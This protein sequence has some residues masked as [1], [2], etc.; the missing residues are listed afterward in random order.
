MPTLAQALR[1]ATSDLS[2]GGVPGPEVDARLLLCAATGLDRVALIRD[3]DLPLGAEAAARFTALVG[4]RL[5]REP[6]SRILGFR[7]FWGLT[8]RVTPDVLDPRPDTKRWSRPSWKSRRGSA[9]TRGASSTSGRVRARSSALSCTTCRERAAGRSTVRPRPVGMARSNLAACGL[10]EAEP[11]RARRLGFGSRGRQLRHRRVEPPLY[12]DRSH[13]RSRSRCARARSLAG[14]GWRGRLDSRPIGSSRPTCLG[15]SCLPASQPSRSARAGRGGLVAAGRCR[16]R[17]P[18][19][20][21]RPRRHRA[22]RDGPE[23][24]C[25]RSS[26]CFSAWK[27]CVIV[28]SSVAERE[29]AVDASTLVA[30]AAAFFVRES[31]CGERRSLIAVSQYYTP[32]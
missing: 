10:A 3:P 13:C 14:P 18:R 1:S 21:P 32:T 29:T 31:R 22:R 25:G 15:F 26:G 4:R 30:F 9:H 5:S 2:E 6:V 8:L 20:P 28:Q 17:R 7:D 19:N 23:V 27:Q 16:S 11:R 24:G 12:R